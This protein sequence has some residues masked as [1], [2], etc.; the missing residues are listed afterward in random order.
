[1]FRESASMD[2]CQLARPPFGGAHRGISGAPKKKPPVAGWSK[3]STRGSGGGGLGG[4]FLG[5]RRD[6]FSF[7]VGLAAF[8]FLDLVVL[9]AHKS[10]Y[11]ADAIRLL[12][13]RDYDDSS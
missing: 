8:A 5:L 10:L 13:G 1:M 11:N 6:L 2:S 7:E 12:V 9:C 3:S 4:A